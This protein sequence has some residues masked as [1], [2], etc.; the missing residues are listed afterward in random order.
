[1]IV[2]QLDLSSTD[3]PQ[4]VKAPGQPIGTGYASTEERAKA[5]A[6]QDADATMAAFAYERQSSAPIVLDGS[7][8]EFRDVMV[9][10]DASVAD[11]LREAVPGCGVRV[12][13]TYVNV[14]TRL[15]ACIQHIL[16]H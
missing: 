11:R 12:Y 4:V 9:V 1:M 5:L 2:S 8:H 3:S 14:R 15:L 10:A 7:P 13:P 6:I 16:A